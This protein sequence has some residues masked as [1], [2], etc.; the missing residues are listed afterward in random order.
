MSG[1]VVRLRYGRLGRFDWLS[2]DT[3]KVGARL[4]HVAVVFAESELDV[5]DRSDVK[6][7]WN[8]AELLL[9]VD[10][11]FRGFVLAVGDEWF[12]FRAAWRTAGLGKRTNGEIIFTNTYDKI[13]KLWRMV[14]NDS[15]PS[16]VLVGDGFWL[17]ESRKFDS[18]RWTSIVRA[19]GFSRRE[20]VTV[21]EDISLLEG[22]DVR[23]Y[24]VEETVFSGSSSR[25]ACLVDRSTDETVGDV[26][27]REISTEGSQMGRADLKF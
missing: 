5:P 22:D 24:I 6:V 19:P 9:L 26:D 7:I 23:H 11:V 25:G 18:E 10:T 4:F 3:N 27:T 21:E 13:V 1:S 16:D 2:I 17:D 8:R 12:P 20:N 15:V 14:R